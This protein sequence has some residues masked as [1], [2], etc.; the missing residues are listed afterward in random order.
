MKR[1][2]V[3]QP[4]DIQIIAEAALGEGWKA[5]LGAALGMSGT[6]GRQLAL[7]GAAGGQAAAIVGLLARALHADRREEMAARARWDAS[8]AQSLALLATYEA[9]LG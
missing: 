1:E 5:K 2:P 4:A 6:R 3:L 7:E 8:E 9:R